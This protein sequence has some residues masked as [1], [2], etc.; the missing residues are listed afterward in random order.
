MIMR[1]F[2]DGGDEDFFLPDTRPS[3]GLQIDSSLMS[4]WRFAPPAPR[5]FHRRVDAVH[6]TPAAPHMSSA[7]RDAGQQQTEQAFNQTLY[8]G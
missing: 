8:F 5:H 6:K 1:A 4:N 7:R 2:D 3:S